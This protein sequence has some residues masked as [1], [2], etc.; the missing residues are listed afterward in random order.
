MVVPYPCHQPCIAV[1]DCNGLVASAHTAPTLEKHL[2]WG[3]ANDLNQVL[4]PAP[5]ISI[6]VIYTGEI[7]KLVCCTLDGTLYVLPIFSLNASTHPEDKK[8]IAPIVVYE[9][10]DITNICGQNISQNTDKNIFIHNFAAGMIHY[11]KF[12][13]GNSKSEKDSRLR[14][15][16][17]FSK[18][19]G[20]MEAFTH[21]ILDTEDEYID[22]CIKDGTVQLLVEYLQG[23][24]ANQNSKVWLDAKRECSEI[25]YE[26]ILKSL[27][28][29]T[30]FDAIRRLLLHLRER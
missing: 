10:P 9:N 30:G 14:P 15:L 20:V 18:G 11:V 5:A 6:G 1:S 3:V 19:E 2:I 27:A 28:S 21:S 16:F 22:D 17:L 23:G 12:K 4:L 26:D 7:V 13:V 8:T 25:Y 29:G 24:E